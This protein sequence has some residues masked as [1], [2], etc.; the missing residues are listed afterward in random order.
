MPLAPEVAFVLARLSPRGEWVGDDDLVFP[1]DRGGYP[2]GSPC[3]RRFQGALAPDVRT[4]LA[5]AAP[6]VIP[7][8]EA[9]RVASGPLGSEHSLESKRANHVIRGTGLAQCAGVGGVGHCLVVV[10]ASRR[11]WAC[12]IVGP[13]AM[14]SSSRSVAR[15]WS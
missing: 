10:R 2:D 14:P 1:G 7:M 9:L 11:A 3:S 12:W 15:A 6:E 8:M 5:E 13:G 4:V